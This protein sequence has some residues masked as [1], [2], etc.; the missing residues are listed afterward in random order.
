MV[1]I[2]THDSTYIY[3]K[4]IHT[5]HVNPFVNLLMDLFK[6]HLPTCRSP[7]DPTNSTPGPKG[8]ASAHKRQRAD[9]GGMPNW[10]SD[11]LAEDVP[12]NGNLVVRF[13]PWKINMDHND[14]GLEDHFPFQTGDL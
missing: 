13:T 2:Y 8:L 4:N 1:Y 9:F 14:G 6:L 10:A 5:S 7:M 11:G 12:Q 3:H